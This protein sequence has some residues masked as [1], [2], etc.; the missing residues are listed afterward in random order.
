MPSQKSD[1]LTCDEDE[2]LDIIGTIKKELKS[3]DVSEHKVEDSANDETADDHMS[4]SE[5]KVMDVDSN[6]DLTS[7]S[8]D[9][10]TALSTRNKLAD[11][12]AID[13]FQNQTETLTTSFLKPGSLFVGSQQSGRSTYEVKVELKEVDLRK[14]YL[15][16]FLTIHGLTE[17]HPEI[18]TFFKG[19]IIGPHYSF[20]TVNETWES[21]K[22]N[23][24]QHWGRFPSWRGLDF[25]A[26]NEAENQHIYDS[27]MGNEYIYMRW[28]ETFLVPDAKIK[29]I[30]GASFAGFYYVCFNQLT[31]SISGLY[32]HERSDKFQQLELCHVPDGGCFPSYQYQ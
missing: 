32:F 26:E 20:Y 15:C 13:F 6:H 2:S 31:G 1:D 17:S 19:E 28:K 8:F 29:D 22:R 18:T 27:Y 24:L 11:K 14:S 23:D 30:V 7:S 21:N 9:P 5:G 25:N 4:H 3:N 12:Y 10:V 16:G